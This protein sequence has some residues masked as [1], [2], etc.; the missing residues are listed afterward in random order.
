VA[1]VPLLFNLSDADSDGAIS[2]EE[3][4]HAVTT[5]PPDKLEPLWR[6][7]CLVLPLAPTYAN[8]ADGG[9]LG[10]VGWRNW[11]SCDVHTATYWGRVGADLLAAVAAIGQRSPIL[12]MLTM[13][14]ILTILAL[15]TLLTRLTRLT[16]L[17]L[18]MHSLLTL[19]TPH[20][21]HTDTTPTLH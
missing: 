2:R 15:L 18:L 19:L 8:R 11:T 21:H 1:L 3:I 5:A 9:V 4:M 14:T 17:T 6:A 12:T 10:R 20:S 13:L 16:L 7:S